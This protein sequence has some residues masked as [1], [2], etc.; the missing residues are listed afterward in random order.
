MDPFAEAMTLASTR[1][2]IYRKQFMKPKTIGLIPHGGYRT[3]DT[4]SNIAIKWLEYI[5]VRF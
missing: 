5:Q 4:Y 3:A 2:R 1:S